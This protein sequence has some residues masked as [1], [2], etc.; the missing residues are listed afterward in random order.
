MEDNV[1]LQLVC[2]ALKMTIHAHG[3]IT[4]KIVGSASKRLSSLLRSTV[5]EQIE[6]DM[7]ES[8]V[9]VIKDKEIERLSRVVKNL[10]KQ[11]DDLLGKLLGDGYLKSPATNIERKGKENG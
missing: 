6:Q 4:W 3:A 5:L 9:L 7:G 10:Q 8:D 1:L 11:R 2:R